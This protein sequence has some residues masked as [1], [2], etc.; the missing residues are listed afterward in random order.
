MRFPGQ[1]RLEEQISPAQKR[2]MRKGM[3]LLPS[4]F[5]AANIGAG[6]FAISHT[7]QGAIPHLLPEGLHYDVWHFDVAAKA[8]GVAVVADGLDGRI[9]R[10]T[11]TTS[12]FGRELDSLAD[13][14]TFGVAPAILA[15][16]WGFRML[17]DFGDAELQTRLVQLGLI[18]TFLFL[19]AGASRLARFNIQVNPQPSNPGRPGRKYFVGLPIPAAAGVIAS[20]VH[21]TSGQ[22]LNSWWLAPVWLAVL[23]LVG[24]LMVS[25]WRFYS[26]KDLNLRN[27]HPFQTLILICGIGALIWFFSHQVLFGITVTYML[28][29]IFTRFSYM[30]RRRPTGPAPDPTYKEAPDAR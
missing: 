12:D 25:T 5:T 14:I 11:N 22:P 23:V 3:Y 28:S 30:L 17:P 19:V 18:V 8:I 2:R 20:V 26:F 7:L 9:A 16:M 13:V 1:Q 27:R 21:L 15:W 4:L 24:F 6:Y 10:M 29:G